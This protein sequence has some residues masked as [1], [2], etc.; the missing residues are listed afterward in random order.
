[1]TSLWPSVVK[2]FRALFPLWIAS[3]AV[4]GLRPFR[5]NDILEVMAELAYVFGSLVLGAHMIGHEHSSRTLGILLVQP[6]DRRRLWIT[7]LAVL[8]PMLVTLA[9]VAWYMIFNQLGEPRPSLATVLLPVFGGLFVAP[10]ITMVFRQQLGGVMV[11]GIV[12]GWS[13]VT[14]SLLTV[15]LSGLDIAQAERLGLEIWTWTMYAFAAI[16]AVLGWR[17]FMRLEAIDG[18][19]KDI[20]LPRWFRTAERAR[21]GHPVWMLIRKEL[22]LQQLT[23]MMAG[24]FAAGELLR[25]ILEMNG[26]ISPDRSVREALITIYVA[27]IALVAGSLA[28]AEERHSGML[29]SQQLLPMPASQQWIIKAGVAVGLALLLG[30]GPVAVLTYADRLGEGIRGALPAFGSGALLILVMTAC[31]LYVSSLSTSGVRA[32]ALA[33]PFLLGTY[34]LFQYVVASMGVIASAVFYAAFLFAALLLFFAG[35]N[36]RRTDR[37]SPRVLWQLGSLTAFIVAGVPLLT[38]LLYPAF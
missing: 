19:G 12:A 20:Q 30:I 25:W 21:G 36:H 4:I 13:M 7:K 18:A 14:I 31:G 8:T 11:T 3:I 37:S 10:W 26:L 6:V 24:F 27:A 5:P 35:A 32:L 33:F 38:V 23:F 16:S 9:A 17:T 15:K 29:E 34:L 22:R 1:M 2:E 28:S